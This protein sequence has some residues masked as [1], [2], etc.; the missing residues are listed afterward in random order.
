MGEMKASK[1]RR[2]TAAKRKVEQC[3]PEE[4]GTASDRLAFISGFPMDA[5]TAANA[6][7]NLFIRAGMDC[8]EISRLCFEGA[9]F[10]DWRY[11]RENCRDDPAIAMCEIENVSASIIENVLQWASA[12]PE[13]D[14]G[15][16]AG[17]FLAELTNRL[18]TES[19]GLK[20]EF[21]D[22]RIKPV[23]ALSVNSTYLNRLR[24]LRKRG[25]G[26]KII[27][28]RGADAARF[29]LQTWEEALTIRSNLLLRIAL[30]QEEFTSLHLPAS[31]ESRVL[32]VLADA[33][34]ALRT[35]KSD[36][37]AI[38]RKVFS[39]LLLDLLKSR[40][41]GACAQF[42]V[43]ENNSQY[44]AKE[45]GMMSPFAEKR[46]NLRGAWLSIAEGEHGL[47]RLL[48]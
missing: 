46:D 32:N 30:E 14:R 21:R 3:P 5:E 33:E 36:R 6:L 25:P 43:M 9:E 23:T 27:K 38:A 26:K 2:V 13:T 45:K 34:S 7:R 39:D 20:T 24:E 8:A 18:V 35:G 17:R 47:N 42:P 28:V 4:A 1:K 12:C 15:R 22:D 16:W 10:P 37:E 29:V 31:E 44:R 41:D 19:P 48:F 11:S 40:W